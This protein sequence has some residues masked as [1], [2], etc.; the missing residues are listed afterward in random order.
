MDELP[1]SKYRPEG[2]L[3]ALTAHYEALHMEKYDTDATITHPT[4][5]LAKFVGNCLLTRVVLI[6]TRLSTRAQNYIIA[7]G[8]P[9][10]RHTSGPKI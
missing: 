9:A 2:Y 8:A 6:N 5:T 1:V 7:S 3:D 4:N 10:R